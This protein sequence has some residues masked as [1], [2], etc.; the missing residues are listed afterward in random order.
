V[1]PTS[2]RIAGFM[3]LGFWVFIVMF[4]RWIG[5]TVR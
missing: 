1:P 3:S 5:F 2:A 4:G